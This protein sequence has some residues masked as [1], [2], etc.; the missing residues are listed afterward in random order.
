MLLTAWSQPQETEETG[1]SW[2]PMDVSKETEGREGKEGKGRKG[3]DRT[4]GVSSRHGPGQRRMR[5]GSYTL[6]ALSSPENEEQNQ[7]NPVGWNGRTRA[8]HYQ[9][10]EPPGPS[11]KVEELN[12]LSGLS[13]VYRMLGEAIILP[14]A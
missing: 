10:G 7:T 2:D 9:D 14:R 3:S 12:P 6:I 11:E 4:R 5:R 8:S 1:A 13:D